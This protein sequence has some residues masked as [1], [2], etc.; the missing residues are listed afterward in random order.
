MKF[1]ASVRGPF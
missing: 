1:P